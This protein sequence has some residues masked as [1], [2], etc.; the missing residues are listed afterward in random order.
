MGPLQ[1]AALCSRPNR[2]TL[3]Y[4]CAFIYLFV[5]LLLL[6]FAA[7]LR[8]GP[9]GASSVEGIE[10]KGS[11]GRYS[12]VRRH[13]RRRRGF[14]SVLWSVTARRGPIV[15]LKIWHGDIQ[16]SQTT[17]DDAQQLGSQ[18]LWGEEA[19]V[20]WLSHIFHGRVGTNEWKRVRSTV[21]SDSLPWQQ[22]VW[23]ISLLEI[24]SGV[25]ASRMTG[26]NALWV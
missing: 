22:W 26:C 17:P 25:R 18:K 10:S 1:N 7:R 24:N 9:R 23:D 3:L 14:W 13:R 4:A 15:W 11:N 2:H 6:S 19:A 5:L 12:R 8:W 20:S 16:T 21:W